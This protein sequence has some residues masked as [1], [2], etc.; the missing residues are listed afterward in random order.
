MRPGRSTA[1]T[2]TA[3]YAALAAL[4]ALMLAG[5]ASI[6][7]AQE[8]PRRA[9]E[10]RP[11]VGSL[12]PLDDRSLWF[13]GGTYTGVQLAAEFPRRLH[14]V[15]S[16]AWT[17]ADNQF[18]ANQGTD[19]WHADVGIETG[20]RRG[21]DDSWEVH[22]LVGAGA[23]VRLYDYHARGTPTLAVPA[24]YVSAAVELQA[25]RVA[26]RGDARLYGSRFES[27]VSAGRRT[28]Y[29][30]AI[31]LGIAYHLGRRGAQPHTIPRLTRPLT[32]GGS[33]AG[34]R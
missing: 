17:R 8:P 4:A 11:F 24:G 9:F 19:I 27:P 16:V 15:T 23:G 28:R 21:L 14:L 7:A 26:L 32:A 33:H 6:A 12:Q 34:D 29:D 18:L 30:V 31:S 13:L 2:R 1:N 10:L 20:P 25:E 22:P 3:R 5:S